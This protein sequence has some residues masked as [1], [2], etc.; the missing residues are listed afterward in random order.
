MDGGQHQEAA[1]D[2]DAPCGFAW[3]GR[4]LRAGTCGNVIGTRAIVC[5]KVRD[6]ASLQVEGRLAL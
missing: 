6:E 5:G 4:E 1:A 2:G 3:K